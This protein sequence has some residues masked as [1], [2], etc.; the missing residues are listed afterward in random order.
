MCFKKSVKKR[1]VCE[2]ENLCLDSIALFTNSWIGRPQCCLALL[3]VLLEPQMQLTANG[4]TRLY[5]KQNISRVL[6]L[7]VVKSNHMEHGEQ[8]YQYTL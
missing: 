3:S 7:V 4:A 5:D 1:T 6:F 2:S 8:T